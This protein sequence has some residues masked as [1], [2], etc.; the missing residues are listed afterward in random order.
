MVKT[1]YGVTALYD[2]KW[3]FKTRDQIDFITLFEVYYFVRRVLDSKNKVQQC[4]RQQKKSETVD[5]TAKTK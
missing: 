5:S 2:K 4:T 1:K 3:N